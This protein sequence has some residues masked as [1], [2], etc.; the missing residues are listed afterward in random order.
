MTIHCVHR[1]FTYLS[2]ERKDL[3][4]RNLSEIEK[5]LLNARKIDLQLNNQDILVVDGSKYQIAFKELTSTSVI[6]YIN[7]Y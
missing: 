1:D 7:E 5:I 4:K 3:F 2:P 6:Y